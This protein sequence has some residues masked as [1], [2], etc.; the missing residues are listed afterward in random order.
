[1]IRDP[2]TGYY[3]PESNDPWADF[4]KRYTTAAEGVLP[5]DPS[6]G[7]TGPFGNFGQF[8]KLKNAGKKFN[9]GISIGG[10]SSSKY[11]SVGMF[12]IF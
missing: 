3:L 6:S 8:I 2:T 9:F 5:L 12:S 4:Q 1:L 10:W 11:F 7:G